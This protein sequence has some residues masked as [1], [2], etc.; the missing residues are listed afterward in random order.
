MMKFILATLALA[1]G[2]TTAIQFQSL[3]ESQYSDA[4]I[5]EVGNLY[6]GMIGTAPLN[7][8]IEKHTG[9]PMPVEIEV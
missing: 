4:T 2:S 8:N 5:A 1:V 7:Y 3:T 9:P 6:K